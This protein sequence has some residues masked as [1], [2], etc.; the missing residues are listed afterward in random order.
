MIAEEF[1]DL[2]KSENIDSYKDEI[3]ELMKKFAELKCDEQKKACFKEAINDSCYD[4]IL[5]TEIVKL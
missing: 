1:F 3:V 4:S 5:Y 2:N